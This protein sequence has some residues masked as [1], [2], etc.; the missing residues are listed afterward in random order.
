MNKVAEVVAI[1][2]LAVALAFIMRAVEHRA[3]V[4]EAQHEQIAFDLPITDMDAPEM[5]AFGTES[6]VER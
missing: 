3:L 4:I 6:E 2:V 1:I 5:A